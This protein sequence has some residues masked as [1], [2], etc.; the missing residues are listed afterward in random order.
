VTAS[1]PAN[2]LRLVNMITELPDEPDGISS[3]TGL[4]ETLKSEACITFRAIVR[5]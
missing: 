4:A 2:P 5:E 3:E 1:V